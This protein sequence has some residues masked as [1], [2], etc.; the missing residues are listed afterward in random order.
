MWLRMLGKN[1][2]HHVIFNAEKH[3]KRAEYLEK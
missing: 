2:G 1:E 3:E